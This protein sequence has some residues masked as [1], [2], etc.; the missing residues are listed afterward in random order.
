MKFEK[1]IHQTYKDENIPSHWLISRDMWQKCHPDYTYM[2]WTDQSI[3]EFIKTHYPDFLG[4]HDKY[5]HNIQ[6]VDMIRYFILYHYGGVYS[7][8]DLY[9]ID[10]IE[11]HIDESC[12]NAD[13]LLVHSGN[14]IK[15][16]TNSF[17]I[18]KK[19]A[20]FWK[21]VHQKLKYP[22]VPFYAIGKHM[23]VL[24]T[25]G[26]AFLNYCIEKYG[27]EKTNEVFN[28]KYLPKSS[29][30]AYAS[31]DDFTVMKPGAVLIPLKGQSWNEWDSHCFNFL[32][33]IVHK[34]IN[35]TPGFSVLTAV[36]FTNVVIFCIVSTTAYLCFLWI[37]FIFT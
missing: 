5:P 16:I 4:I 10:N 18:S 1:I 37:K 26:S 7:D 31:F 23:T 14:R 17:M 30:M 8:L 33:K 21:F 19:G 2:F 22:E 29:F 32:N 34:T 11:N 35:Y 24:N 12:A 36:V 6:R 9:P 28:I 15:C 13:V 3:R 20:L 25:T 27:G